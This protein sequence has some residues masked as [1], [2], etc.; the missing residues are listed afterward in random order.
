MLWISEKLNYK[1]NI[2]LS[3]DKITPTNETSFIGLSESNHSSI[4]PDLI[5]QLSFLLANF[6]ETYENQFKKQATEATT[7]KNTTTKAVS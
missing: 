1:C 6:V 7:K 4:I 5:T 2:A 3:I